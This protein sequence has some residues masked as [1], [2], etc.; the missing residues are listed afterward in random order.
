MLIRA[1]RAIAML[2]SH[3]HRFIF[4]SNRKTASTSIEI[5]LSSLCRRGDII[6]PFAADEQLRR[7][8][9]YVK[10]QNYIPWNNKLHYLR[11]AGLLPVLKHRLGPIRK[12]IGFHSH[13]TA[14]E[15]LKYLPLKTWDQ[16]YKF[17]FVR[18]P[19]DRVLSDYHWVSRD[20][21]TKPSLDEF[22]ASARLA[23]LAEQSLSL[24]TIDGAVAVNR[25]C[26]YED[27]GG[28]LAFLFAKF[29]GGTPP[30]LP[31]AKSSQ[32][33]DRRHYREVLSSDQAERI[34]KIFAREI[35]LTGYTY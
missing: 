2:V 13:M 26:K 3:G 27:L 11:F 33:V 30:P 29:G 10:P 18:N 25:V 17:C 4:L 35:E 31:R 12:K 1:T 24:Y 7:E 6:T 32:R 21:S 8:R 15:V 19:W 14:A 5:A 16:Y 9:G 22:I 23:M 28:E 20:A 34:A